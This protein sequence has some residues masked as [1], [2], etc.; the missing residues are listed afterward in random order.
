MDRIPIP[1]PVK[2]LLRGVPIAFMT[3]L[4]PDGRLSTNPVALLYENDRILVSTVTARQK[5]R[6]LLADDRVTLCVVQPGNLNRY[7][8]IRGRALI[9]PDRDRR[10]IDEIAR[11]YMGVEHYPLDREGDERVVV[12]IMPE[13]VLSPAIPFADAPPYQ[14]SGAS[15]RKALVAHREQEEV[16][17]DLHVLP[18]EKP[19]DANLILGQ[20]HFIKTV[21]D[22]YEAIVG[23]STQI[24]FGIAFCEASGPRLVRRAGN[25]DMLTGLAVRNALA[26]GAGHS[27]VVLLREGFPLNVLNAIKQVP[28][29]CRVFCA[30]AN[31]VEV[32]VAETDSGRGIVGV[33]DGGPPLGVETDADVRDRHDLLR[34][35]GYKL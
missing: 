29:V 20:A 5:Y 32:L 13:Q 3:T 15:A 11:V 4:R 19:E 2:P 7:V 22:L 26:I 25:D 35:I 21:E 23:I 10:V 1:T 31:P 33:V 30:T 14:E 16:G 12:E 6:N 24:R 34:R 9:E 18:L 27:F 17:L 28:E 8:E